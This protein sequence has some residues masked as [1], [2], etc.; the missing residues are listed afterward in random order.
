MFLPRDDL[1]A[2]STFGTRDVPTQGASCVCGVS[3]V[4]TCSPSPDGAFRGRPHLVGTHGLGQ[5]IAETREVGGVWK[6]GSTRMKCLCRA[7][8][9]HTV[10]GCPQAVHG[11]DS[12]PLPPS[13]PWRPV[14]A[15]IIIKYISSPLTTRRPGCP[16][17]WASVA[18]QQ[19]YREFPPHVPRP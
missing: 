8:C 14:A 9:Q 17:R 15:H 13:E 18:H 5:G 1:I 19:G 6:T 16:A 11:G 12:A 4:K 10:P 7:R 2:V 3:M